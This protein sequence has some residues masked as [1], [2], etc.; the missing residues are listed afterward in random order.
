MVIQVEAVGGKPED[1]ETRVLQLG[2]EVE[3][4]V[5]DNKTLGGVSGLNWAV[6][7]GW[8]LDDLYNDQGSLAELT[9]TIT[10]NARLT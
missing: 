7:S 4:C 5:A 6:V 2:L 9:Y 1:A 10:Y 3:E 8:A